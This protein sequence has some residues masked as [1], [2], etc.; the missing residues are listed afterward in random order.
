MIRLAGRL[1]E[2]HSRGATLAKAFAEKH[3]AEAY[4]EV[5]LAHAPR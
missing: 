2:S 4:V 3:S 5:L 1:A